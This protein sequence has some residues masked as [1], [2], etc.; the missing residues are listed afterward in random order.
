MRKL[1]ATVAGSVAVVWLFSA[2]A[3]AQYAYGPPPI[4]F[5]QAQ[6]LDP[7]PAS[8]ADPLYKPPVRTP[9]GAIAGNFLRIEI[10][11]GN[12][13]MGIVTLKDANRTVAVP[14]QH[15]RID[16]PTGEILTDLSWNELNS[17]PSG[18]LAG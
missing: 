5:D 13:P 10:H 7:T 4:A 2:P 16:P 18:P 1:L 11:D 17:I 8:P 12:R 6:P 15:L 3:S 14:L 9:I